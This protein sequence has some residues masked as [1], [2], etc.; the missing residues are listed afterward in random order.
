MF[1]FLMT[2]KKLMTGEDASRI[3]SSEA[4]RSGGGVRKGGF[5]SRAQAAASRNEAPSNFSG[6]PNGQPNGACTIL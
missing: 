2:K 5:A 1:H 3:Q 4:R 6:Q